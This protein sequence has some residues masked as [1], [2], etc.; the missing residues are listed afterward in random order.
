[1]F[2]RTRRHAI[3]RVVLALAFS[4]AVV[5]GQQAD[6]TSPSPSKEELKKQKKAEKKASK[7][8]TKAA[9][10][11]SD[12]TIIPLAGSGSQSFSGEP[13]CITMTE[14]A[15]HRDVVRGWGGLLGGGNNAFLGVT[16]SLR[17][18]ASNA[19]TREATVA[20]SAEFYDSS[21][22]Q[23]GLGFAQ[24][25]VP[26]TQSNPFEIAWSCAEGVYYT[27]VGS[28]SAVWIPNC[29]AGTARYT[30]SYR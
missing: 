22:V 4:G 27:P 13:G 21:G 18:I 23:L 15:F 16:S 11:A 19:C 26:A 29:S 7:G 25:L 12:H 24:I 6:P 14:M 3:L 10:E 9:R 2:E 28:N 17:G 1:M 5:F 30:M 20:I 8:A